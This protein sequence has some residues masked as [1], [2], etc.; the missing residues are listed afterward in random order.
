MSCA[1]RSALFLAVLASC[2]AQARAAD[3][4]ALKWKF[5]PG[6]TSR[7][8]NSN[9]LKASTK[10]GGLSQEAVTRHTSHVRWAVESVDD[11]GNAHITQTLERIRVESGP[12]D[13]AVTF[14]SNDEKAPDGLDE[15]QIEAMRIGVN[16]PLNLVIDPLGKVIDVRLSEQFAQKLKESPHYGQLA[17]MYSRDN[18]K[19]LASMITIELPAEPVSKG[20]VWEQHTT[21]NDPVAGKQKLTTTYRYDGV[22]EHDGRKLDKI[23]ATAKI[24]LADENKAALIS[25]KDQKLSG[26]IWFDRSAGR[27]EEAQMTSRLVT[28]LALGANKTERTLVI[29]QHTQLVDEAADK[30]RKPQKPAAKKAAGEDL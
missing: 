14:D 27:V 19:Q 4:V 5:K 11:D 21:V 13:D 20:A 18:L 22:E 24:S 2:I 15:A 9:D 28:E 6:S 23:S 7:F 10:G 3:G 25:I 8:V 26:V 17:A 29:K 1:V 16:Q 12:A 30:D